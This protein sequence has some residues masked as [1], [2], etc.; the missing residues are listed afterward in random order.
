MYVW[1]KHM[2]LLPTKPWQ[3]QLT[4]HITYQPSAYCQY[5]FL[6]LTTKAIAPPACFRVSHEVGQAPTLSW[7]TCWHRPFLQGWY[8]DQVCTKNIMWVLNLRTKKKELLKRRW[9]NWRISMF[10]HCRL[11]NTYTGTLRIAESQPTSHRSCRW[12]PHRLHEH[13][14]INHF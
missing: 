2:G 4:I 13:K 6:Y 8:S 3:S 1:G 10:T 11:W 7:A 9:Q 12:Q 14:E 5:F